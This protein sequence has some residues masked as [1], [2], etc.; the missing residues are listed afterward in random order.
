MDLLSI[1]FWQELALKY[2]TPAL[3]LNS[4]IEAIF[5]P[6]PPDVLLIT[7]CLTEPQN[8]FFYAL[9]ATLFSS[10]G[11]IG[12][13]YL[14]LLGGKPLAIKFFGEEKVRKV[15]NLYDRY[16]SLVIL[17]AGFTPLPYKVFTVTSGVLYAS[18]RKLF[19]FS[20]LG[21]GSRFFLEAYLVKNYGKDM[22]SFIYKNL[23]ILTLLVGIGVIII[24]VAYK[25]LKGKKHEQTKVL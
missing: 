11:G 16:E 25:K 10:L 22:V 4:F 3:A 21:R 14:G 12:G 23:N 13:Y 24:F 15:H 7:L 6:I 18:L 9:I 20:L 19:I 5:F 1:Q 8:A 2:G 17:L